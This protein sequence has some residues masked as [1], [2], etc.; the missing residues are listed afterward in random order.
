MTKNVLSL[1]LILVSACN[2]YIESTSFGEIKFTVPDSFELEY[3][4]A[5]DCE[6][7]RACRIR[8]LDQLVKTDLL[9]TQYNG[10]ELRKSQDGWIVLDH[11]IGN[12]LAINVNL[13]LSDT[14]LLEENGIKTSVF[15]VI[16]KENSDSFHQSYALFEACQKQYEISMKGGDLS[17]NEE[18]I[19]YKHILQ[20]LNC[21]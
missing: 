7:S 13:M 6:N 15:R 20:S 2:G 5:Y 21:K 12:K 10:P 19:V 16:N 11:R 1:L 17:F 8:F 4:G 9:I 14:L 3:I 18:L